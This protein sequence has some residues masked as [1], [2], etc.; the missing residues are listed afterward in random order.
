MNMSRFSVLM[1]SMLWPQ[2][3]TRNASVTVLTPSPSSTTHTLQTI[4]FVELTESMNN[5]KSLD[6]VE[7]G[8]KMLRKG[9][10]RLRTLVMRERISLQVGGG[11]LRQGLQAG[12]KKKKCSSLTPLRSV[13][14]TSTCWIQAAMDGVSFA[15]TVSLSGLELSPTLFY[16]RHA[17]RKSPFFLVRSV[18][19]DAPHSD[20]W[21][22]VGRCQAA[23]TTCH[24]CL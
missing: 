11:L 17:L 10:S 2:T 8:M 19:E 21:Q 24:R 5:H 16:K 9:I 1:T 13:C 18:R 22:R 7:V 15:Q 3:A 20:V 14:T 23:R 12:S 6:T 4:P